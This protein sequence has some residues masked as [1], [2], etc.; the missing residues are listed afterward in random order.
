MAKIKFSS[1]KFDVFQ[2]EDPAQD[3]VITH[4]G[5]WSL[6]DHVATRNYLT[7]G[8]IY[9][10]IDKTRPLITELSEFLQ[11]EY[12]QVIGFQLS[13]R[14][15]RNRVNEPFDLKSFFESN[16]ELLE[17]FSEELKQYPLEKNFLFY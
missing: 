10:L 9:I 15:Y 14:H 13:T 7:N 8:P 11:K 5:Y 17:A 3:E 6:R 12:E 1:D 16:P 4:L 2:I